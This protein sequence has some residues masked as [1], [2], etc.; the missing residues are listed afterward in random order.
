MS[1]PALSLLLLLAWT[2]RPAWSQDDGP[3]TVAGE[4]GSGGPT[5]AATAPAD[6]PPTDAEAAP[7]PPPAEPPAANGYARRIDASL[8]AQAAPTVM[9]CM[10][11]APA[12]VRA[13]GGVLAV[14]LTVQA[15]GGLSAVEPT[16]AS[17]LV[18]GKTQACLVEGFGIIRLPHPPEGTA[19]VQL[20]YALQIP[21]SG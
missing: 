20:D 17:T 1:G 16:A 3:A 11:S 13:A 7:P 8:Q 6:E 14:Q 18:H 21:P 15:D 19:P 9:R 2:V 12:K 4:Q 5:E 10:A